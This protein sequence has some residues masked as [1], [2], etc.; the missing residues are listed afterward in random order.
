MD[1]GGEVDF[2]RDVILVNARADAHQQK[3]YDFLNSM[4]RRHGAQKAAAAAATA[5]AKKAQEDADVA[6]KQTV[7]DRTAS[8]AGSMMTGTARVIKAKTIRFKKPGGA[9]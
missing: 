5:A 3:N 8:V 6:A 9:A 7:I 4:S 1:A 2:E